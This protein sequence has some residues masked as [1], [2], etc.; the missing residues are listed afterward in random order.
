MLQDKETYVELPKQTHD[1]TV[2]RKLENLIAKYAQ[3]LTKDEIQFTT[4]FEYSSSNI[5]GLPKLHNC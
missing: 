3:C 5:Y 4:K 1:S 2:M